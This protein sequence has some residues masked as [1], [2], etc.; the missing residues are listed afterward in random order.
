MLR[1]HALRRAIAVAIVLGVAGGPTVG[2]ASGAGGGGKA[3][4]GPCRRNCPDVTAP[5][6]AISAPSAGAVVSGAIEVRGTASDNVAVT[7]VRVAVG[8]GP[9][10]TASG[11]SN[12]SLMVD[13]RSYADGPASIAVQAADGAGNA[14]TAP[15]TVTID[16]AAD[17]VAPTVTIASPASGSTVAGSV[18]VSGT[19]A[20]EGGVASVAVTVDDGPPVTA[21][22][23]TA[24]STVLDA[25]AWTAGAH[26]VSARA[27][28]AA[29]N[30]TVTAISLQLA[31]ILPPGTGSDVVIT[32]P[33]ATGTLSP[34]LR[35]RLI[36]RGDL[37]GVLYLDQPTY[38][39]AVYFRDVTTRATSLV[40]LPSD[41]RQG[42]VY[43]AAAMPTDTDL[44]IMGGNGPL[45]LRRFRLSGSPLPTAA[46]L[47]ETRTFGDTD[48]RPGDMISLASGALVVAWHQ[49]G[50]TGPHGQHVAY[51]NPAGAW[52]ELPAL[53]F[54]PTRASDQV[55][56]QHPAD[57]SVWLFCNPD[58]WTIGA[59]HLSEGS[60][61]LAVD[62]SDGTYLTSQ[63]YGQYG[64]DP[65]NP[66][67]AVAA[68][69]ASGTLALAYQ[70][71]DRRILTDGTST[72]LTSRVAVA[73]IPGA[74]GPS[75][76]VAPAYAEAVSDVGLVV[77]PGETVVSYH[78][79][80]EA[81]LEFDELHVSRHRAG[82]WEA[83][84]VLGNGGGVG[85]ASGRVELAAAMA[86]GGLHLLTI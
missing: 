23:T 53:T 41:S 11:T 19:A 68:D 57:G 28:D 45:T 34:L 78:P 43:A 62:W 52:S 18:S 70:S 76:I 10:T 74:G 73:R 79:V 33:R 49:Q 81:T 37:T 36:Q 16:N 3:G 85:Y 14:T 8:G 9:W 56:A 77:L 40:D 51:W 1:S 83:P 6:M 58:A 54:M 64:P 72:V 47:V 80:D 17:T 2:T 84:L 30:V 7:T 29:G 82:T 50:T 67:L 5:S 32:D 4:G 44:W 21:S 86:D 26:T 55:L 25:T 69:P 12:W 59:T 24:W 63:E 31:S 38:R 35:T 48:S 65:E 60:E 20:D 42:W 66:D 75:F 13:S 61:G 46:T 39:P 71:S 15:V 22:G 27:T